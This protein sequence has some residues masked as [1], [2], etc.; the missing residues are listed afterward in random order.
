MPRTDPARRDALPAGTAVREYTLESVIGHGG[1]GI[2]YRAYHGELGATVAIKEYLPLELA[3]REGVAVRVRSD[4]DTA[5]FEDGLRRFR[6]EARA[7]MQ[8]QDHPGIVS[9]RAFFRASG[10]AYMVMEYEDGR[11]LAEVLAER[12]SAGRPFG[13]ADLL[14]VMVPL[15]NGL[16]RVHQAGLL[17]RDIKPS[18]ILIRRV[19][20]HP[21]LIDFGASKQVVANQSK[22]MAPYTEGYAAM[23]QVADA[24][25]L[26][27]WTDMY[28]VGAVMW[29]MVAGGQPPWQPPHP[30]RVETRSHA[31]LRNDEDPLPSALQLGQGRFTRRLLDGIDNC[32]ILQ[33]RRRVQDCR[34][35][36][37][38]L[39]AKPTD[40]KDI[41]F[42]SRAAT[43]RESPPPSLGAVL[44]ARWTPVL[45]RVLIGWVI[46]R[47]A[48]LALPMR[49]M[50][51]L[52][53]PDQILSCN[54]RSALEGDP[55]A[56]HGLGVRIQ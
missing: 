39:R 15:L 53:P 23:E 31:V 38:T 35:L 21:V 16:E 42:K 19:D 50:R 46:A 49:L 18:N 47:T 3:V 5:T 28:G 34:E 13:Q 32:L 55:A 8:F 52:R 24:G 17:H 7:L 44:R 37:G 14:G 10:T 11:T 2:V 45:L 33:E 25:D 20:G 54:V 6:D 1:F 9:C 41:Q 56:Q 48:G 4:A 40:P 30:T 22:S 29:R 36:L 43:V 26:G 27:P 12:E 51:D